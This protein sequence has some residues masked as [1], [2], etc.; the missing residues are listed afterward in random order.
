MDGG[1]ADTVLENTL[2]YLGRLIAVVLRIESQYPFIIA[3][4]LYFRPSLKNEQDSDAFTDKRV[5]ANHQA[6]G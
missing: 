5:E 4:A 3:I 2:G 1:L 6:M